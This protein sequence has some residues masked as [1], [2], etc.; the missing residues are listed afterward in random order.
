LRLRDARAGEVE[1]SA[2]RLHHLEQRE[3]AARRVPAPLLLPLHPLPGQGD[4]G[5]DRLGALPDAEEVAAAR[6]DGSVLRGARSP[7]A[8]EEALDL[9]APRLAE[10]APRRGHP[11]GSAALEGP[12]D[13]HPAAAR[14]AP[15]ERAGRASF[16]ASGVHDARERRLTVSPC[17]LCG[18][19]HQLGKR[20]GDVYGSCAMIDQ[21][22]Q[23]CAAFGVKPDEAPYMLGW[24]DGNMEYRQRTGYG[25]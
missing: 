12:Q 7:R 14:R 9:R 15:E 2:D 8:E 10:A 18:C 19:V 1:A 24:E 22:T 11:S 13:H 17:T 3:G 23:R 21:Y 6:G 25:G 5:E 4:D 20:D 16:R